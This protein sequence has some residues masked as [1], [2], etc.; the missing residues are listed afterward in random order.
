MRYFNT[1]RLRTSASCADIVNDIQGTSAECPYKQ[2]V[3]PVQSSQIDDG[4]STAA[5]S[6]PSQVRAKEKKKQTMTPCARLLHRSQGF[7]S[8]SCAPQQGHATRAPTWYMAYNTLYVVLQWTL[9]GALG[10][11][12]VAMA[13]FTA[14]QQVGKQQHSLPHAHAHTHT[15]IQVHTWTR[16]YR[17]TS[18]ARALRNQVAKAARNLHLHLHLRLVCVCVYIASSSHTRVSLLR[19]PDHNNLLQATGPKYTRDNRQGFSS[20]LRM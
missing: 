15:Y 3:E 2:L 12:A 16:I 7:C 19:Y 13:I 5:C 20:M 8:H 10:C 18:M 17:H 11:L 14:N 4:E 9:P 6:N 1:T